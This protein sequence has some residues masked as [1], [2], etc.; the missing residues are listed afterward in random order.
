M[1]NKY[2]FTAVVSGDRPILV[3]WFKQLEG[4]TNWSLVRSKTITDRSTDADVLSSLISP[5][6]GYDNFGTFYVRVSNIATPQPVSSQFVKVSGTLPFA[7]R[8]DNAYAVE[9]EAAT[10]HTFASG[11]YRNEQYVYEWYR[12]GNLINEATQSSYTTANVASADQTTYGVQISSNTRGVSS[13]VTTLSVISSTD[14][15]WDFPSPTLTT[16]LSTF[17]IT[18]T[19]PNSALIAWGDGYGTY[20]TDSQAASHA[21]I[22]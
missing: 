14:V 18:V 1:S 4:Q 11:G 13:F 8:A 5:A 20:L 10:F 12:E 6:S 2:T 7:A 17:R 22:V 19:S 16:R 3:E 21:Y 15:F 9:G